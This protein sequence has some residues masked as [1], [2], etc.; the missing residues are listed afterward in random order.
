M[1]EEGGNPGIEAAGG[2]R[3]IAENKQRS[4]DGPVDPGAAE[5]FLG[6]IADQD[7]QEGKHPLAE[8]L[9][10]ADQR[11]HRRVRM[12]VFED[13]YLLRQGREPQQQAHGDKAGNKR[14]EDGGEFREE[15]LNTAGL[16]ALQRLFLFGGDI[17][18][19]WR[20]RR[21]LFQ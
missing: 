7:A 8:Y 14:G 9:H 20:I 16:L 10:V 1:A 15:F 13:K 2:F 17:G 19:R 3:V 6:V 11:H 5:G 12:R 4:D 18:Q 21:G